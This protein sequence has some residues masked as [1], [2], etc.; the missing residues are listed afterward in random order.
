MFISDN[1]SNN[2]TL[3]TSLKHHMSR[4][5]L[6]MGCQHR[7]RCFAHVLNL[8]MQVSLFHHTATTPLDTK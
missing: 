6:L 1:T 5:G 8:V 4:G 7:V 2:D 3:A